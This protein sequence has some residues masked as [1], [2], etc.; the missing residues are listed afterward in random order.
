[1]RGYGG[2]SDGIGISQG[3]AIRNIYGKIDGSSAPAAYEVFGEIDPTFLI[4]DGAFT[5]IFS[6]IQYV[7]DSGPAAPHMTGFSFDASK[8][9]PTANENRPVNKAVRYLIKAQ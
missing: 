2:N 8:I 5:G 1:M 4:I 6:N 9:V 7:A 3:D